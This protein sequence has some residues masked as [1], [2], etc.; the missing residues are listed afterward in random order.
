VSR[1]AV[2]FGRGSARRLV[3]SGR[4]SRPSVI[5]PFVDVL[6]RCWLNRVLW[7]DNEP[8]EYHTL[9][10]FCQTLTHDYPMWPQPTGAPHVSR[11]RRGVE[12]S[13]CAVTFSLRNRSKYQAN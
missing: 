4:A 5:P 6:A 2:R 13:R 12:S 7:R 3:V 11:L 8:G 10:L 9:S 1:G